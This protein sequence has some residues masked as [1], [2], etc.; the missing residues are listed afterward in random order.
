MRAVVRRDTGAGYETFLR[1]LAAAS[2]I[3]TPTRAELARMDRKRRKKGS[4]DDWTHPKDPDAKV[5]K[6]KDGRTRLA[7]KAEHAV[8]LETS[9]VVG[10]SVQDADAG[11]TQTMLETLVTAAEQVDAVQPAGT[12]IAELVCDKGYHSNQVL[13]TLA[14]VGI[15]SY[16]SEP[17]RGRR[18]WRGK[19]AAR[20]AVYANRQRICGARGKRLLRRRGERLERP[21]A[22]LYATGR[23]RRVHLRGHGN[24]LKR[25]LLQACGLNL[26]LLMRRLMGVGTPRGLQGRACD[27]FDA[28]RLALRRFWN[29]VS[30]ST[31]ARAPRLPT[32]PPPRRR[33][34][35]SP[36]GLP[37]SAPTLLPSPASTEPFPL[38]PVTSD[39][40]LNPCPRKLGAPQRQIATTN[41]LPRSE[42]SRKPVRF[43]YSM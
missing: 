14:E 20:D 35:R 3:A 4:N 16:V 43:R 37:P 40:P 10:V 15:R 28:L 32:P 13:V 27:L 30:R 22:H 2:G 21:N 24:I 19:H 26:G 31:A 33:R 34:L 36:S 23:L 25:V 39:S 9:A 11:D 18:N 41:P 6:M 29:L 7:H 12:G 5:T 1:Q 8:D 17:A 42:A 38:P